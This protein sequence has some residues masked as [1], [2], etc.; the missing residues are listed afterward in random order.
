MSSETYLEHTCNDRTPYTYLIGWSSHNKWYYGVRYGKNSHPSDL[1]KTYFTSS[2]LVKEFVKIHGNPDIIEIRKIFSNIVSAKNHEDKVLRRMN[3]GAS[4]KWLNVKGDSFKNLDIT[5]VNHNFGKDNP[6][7]AYLSDPIRAKEF[8]IKIS[9]GVK[10]GQEKSEKAQEQ[11]KWFIEVYLKG[12]N[13]PGKQARSKETRLRN[14]NGLKEFYKANP[15]KIPSGEKNGM[16]G[17]K[18]TE[19]TKQRMRNAT[20]TVTEHVCEV[21][22]KLVKQNRNY[23]SHL[24]KYHGMD[25]IQSLTLLEKSK[26]RIQLADQLLEIQEHPIV[27]IDDKLLGDHQKSSQHYIC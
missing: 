2:K 17:K 12:E 16:Y 26:I 15:D 27:S 13:A 22:N 3:V 24:M 4:E 1:W 23:V 9:N 8:S 20:R 14:S 18:H 25:K 6:I 10:L 21:C 7:H 5:K 11:R 19:V